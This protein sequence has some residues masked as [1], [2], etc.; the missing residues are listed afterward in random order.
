MP[1]DPEELRDVLRLAAS[2]TKD[3]SLFAEFDADLDGRISKVEFR[4]SIAKLGFH[5]EKRDA[6]ALFNFLDLKHEGAVEWQTLNRVLLTGTTDW[7]E[8]D[9]PAPAAA[10][11]PAPSPPFRAVLKPAKSA[12]AHPLMSANHGAS[13]PRSVSVTEE[14]R[15]TGRVSPDA[16]AAAGASGRSS[17]DVSEVVAQLRDALTAH[18]TR[19]ID[20]FSEW[21]D[22]GDGLVSKSEF[23]KAMPMI[24]LQVSRRGEQRL[25]SHLLFTPLMCTRAGVAARRGA[26]LRLVRPRR[27]RPHRL[28]R[29]E[30]AAAARAGRHAAQGAAGETLRATMHR[31]DTACSHLSIHA[32]AG[33]RR[34]R[35]LDLQEERARAAPQ[36]VLGG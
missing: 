18:A 25:R 21:D 36:E 30:Q 5:A 19:V 17:P 28:P 8:D 7:A 3:G 32:C 11:A 29:A 15:R 13:A 9:P 27:V 23:R 31:C 26:A 6:D 35:D 20:L 33:G 16:T 4:R 1:H 14:Q 2:R 34:G 10:A 24:G 22:D 12:S